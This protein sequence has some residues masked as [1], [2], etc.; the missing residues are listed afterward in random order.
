MSGNAATWSALANNAVTEE[1]EAVVH[2][3][4]MG[5]L[6]IQ[7]ELQLAFKETSALFAYGFSNSADMY[8]VLRLSGIAAK[9]Y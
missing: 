5:L 2:M 9:L 4:D 1:H 6:H 8:I 3:C 7:C